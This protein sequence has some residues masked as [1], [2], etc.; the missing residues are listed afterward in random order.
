MVQ[1]LKKED[2]ISTCLEIGGNKGFLAQSLIANNVVDSAWVTD[3]DAGAI[4]L[5]YSRC[6]EIEL[7]CEKIGFSV[8]NVFNHYDI[9]GGLPACERYKSDIVFALAITHHLIL[10]QKI[11][12]ECI[13]KIFAQYTN[14]YLVIEFMPLGL[15]ASDTINEPIPEWYT[16]DW[17]LEGMKAEFEVLK[18]EQTDKN[19]ICILLKRWNHD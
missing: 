9:A 4:E 2:E 7:I 10:S 3:Y 18:V 8:L 6:K 12:L 19:R 17:F 1:N 5:G 13:T 15:W 14:K 16:L 11:S